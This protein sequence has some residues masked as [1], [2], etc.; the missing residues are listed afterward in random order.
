M[1]VSDVRPG[2]VGIGRTVFE[3][4]RL[5]EFKVHILGVIQNVIGP[6][7]S[8]ILAKLEGGPLAQTGVIAGMSGSPVYIDGRLVGAVSYSLGQ[9]SKEPIAGITP[10]DEMIE[11][12]SGALTRPAAARPQVD[13][14]SSPSELLSAFQRALSWNAPF[15]ARA[16]DAR[17]EGTD[18]IA[19]IG[20]RDLGTALRPIATPLVMSGFDPGVADTIGDL[21]RTQGFVPM[22]AGQG[23]PGERPYDGPLRPGDAVGVTIVSGDLE[24]GATGTV[25]HIDGARVYAFGHPLYNLGPIEFPMT[26]AY[27]YTLLPSLASSS[28]LAGTGEVIGTFAQDRATAIAGTL[29]AGPRLVPVKLTLQSDHAVAQTF[30]FSVVND[31]MFTPLMTYAALLNTLGSY[32]RQYGATTFTVRGEARLAGHGTIALD[33][34]FAGDQASVGAAAYIAAP[35]TALL[36]N[37]YERA[38][39]EGLDLAIGSTE[40]PRTTT[41][42]RVWVD[43]PRVR[44]GHPVAVKVLLRHWRGETELRTITVTVPPTATGTLSLV[45]SDAARLAQM[46]VRETRSLSPRSSIPQIVRAANKV[47]RNN[48]LYVKL[49][50]MMPGAMVN[51][52][53]LAALPPSVLAVFDGDRA[54]GNVGALQTLT[55]G[56]WELTLDRAVTGARTLSL[57]VSNN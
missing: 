27:I 46:E 47:R 17:L 11:A 20:A 21:F 45:V 32:E 54:S 53:P 14:P 7:R 55:L 29:G 41:I 4:T 12:S 28:K 30:N 43:D 10:I 50:A 22:R 38:Q 9:F 35:I 33:N 16:G 34:I 3:T 48:R 37:D 2:M 49:V 57:I 36:G 15:S 51:G 39:L 44:P 6:R 1:P 24:L 23:A 8:L 19:G 52:E 5:D 25:T 40:T 26:R 18:V 13:L 56:E 42:E 31:P